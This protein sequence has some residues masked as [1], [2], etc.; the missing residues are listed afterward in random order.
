ML[1]FTS[2]ISDFHDISPIPSS[3]II[4]ILKAGTFCTFTVGSC[5]NTMWINVKKQKC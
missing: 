2:H 5:S 3:E 4:V 1:I